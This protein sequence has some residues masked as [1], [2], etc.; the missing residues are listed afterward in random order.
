MKTNIHFLIISRSVLLRMTNLSDKNRRKNQNIHSEE[1]VILIAFPLQQLLQ[2]DSSMLRYTYIVYLV[3]TFKNNICQ[4]KNKNKTKN[5]PQ[6][7]NTKHTNRR[8]WIS[9]PLCN[10][11]C[12]LSVLP[13]NNAVYTVTI[14]N[15]DRR[16][17]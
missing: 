2:E 4:Y 10:D 14:H 5:H 9:L 12:W 7:I 15:T 8:P 1:Y 16:L 6:A 13:Q 17:L 3:Y 11:C